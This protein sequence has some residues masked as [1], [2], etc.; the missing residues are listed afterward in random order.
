MDD[1]HMGVSTCIY[2]LVGFL[3]MVCLIPQADARIQKELDTFDIGRGMNYVK[4]ATVLTSLTI[5]AIGIS[6]GQGIL[7]A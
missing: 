5:I 2:T 1:S 4:N 3:V 7:S 6:T